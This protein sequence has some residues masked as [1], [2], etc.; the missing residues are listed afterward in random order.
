MDRNRYHINNDYR[1]GY[2]EGVKDA[3]KA[4]N[5]ELK[6]IRNSITS[7]LYDLDS[8]NK[9]QLDS[10][11][12][13]CYECSYFFPMDNTCDLLGKRLAHT[14][15]ECNWFVRVGGKKG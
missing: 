2:D 3:K 13:S 15:S 7:I 12:Y 14:I 11:T 6:R 4:A 10:Q 9:S 1:D 8:H 5:D